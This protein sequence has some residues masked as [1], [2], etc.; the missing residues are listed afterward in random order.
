MTNLHDSSWRATVNKNIPVFEI[1]KLEAVM[2]EHLNDFV[3]RKHFPVVN[4]GFICNICY[5][6]FTFP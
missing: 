5:N 3:G 4:S 6:P 1:P 2:S